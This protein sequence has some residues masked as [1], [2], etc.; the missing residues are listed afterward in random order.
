MSAV[1]DFIVIVLAVIGGW[2]VVTIAACE[3]WTRIRR[4]Q[5]RAL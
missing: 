5:G 2:F 3:A 4:R 1:V